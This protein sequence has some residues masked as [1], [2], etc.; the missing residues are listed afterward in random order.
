MYMGNGYQHTHLTKRFVF[1]S[2]GEDIIQQ[3]GGRTQRPQPKARGRAGS[4]PS[5]GSVSSTPKTALSTPTAADELIDKTKPQ[6]Q[7]ESF[8]N[9]A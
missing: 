6:S 2:L 7:T 8:K 1:F 3:T 4:P 5:S 9:T